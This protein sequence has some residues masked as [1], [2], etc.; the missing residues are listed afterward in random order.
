MILI[1][2]LLYKCRYKRKSIKYVLL[3]IASNNNYGRTDQY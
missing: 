2:K 3:Y 1:I